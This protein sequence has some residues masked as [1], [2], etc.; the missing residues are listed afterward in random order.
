M[1][2][3]IIHRLLLQLV[4]Q[5]LLLLIPNTD[6]TSFANEI[7][8]EMPKAQFGAHF[9][10]WFATLLVAHPSVEEVFATDEQLTDMLRYTG[11]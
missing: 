1:L 7:V 3:S 4:E 10:S 9:G 2:H 11:S 8:Q 6:L 5:D